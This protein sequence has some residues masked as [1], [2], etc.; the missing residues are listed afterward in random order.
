[1]DV[2]RVKQILASPSQIEVHYHGVPVWIDSCD[3]ATGTANVHDL[4][5]AKKETVQVKVS[6]LKEIS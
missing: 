2:K 6:E 1:M 4:K 3:E 5:S